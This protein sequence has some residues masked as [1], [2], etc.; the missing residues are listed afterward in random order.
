MN[1]LRNHLS[2]EPYNGNTCSINNVV[3][4]KS[5]FSIHTWPEYDYRALNIITCRTEIK[6][7]K[8]L[9][10]LNKELGVGLIS[11]TEVKRGILDFPVRILYKPEV[12]EKCVI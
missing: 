4:S 7:K 5:H 2:V 6:S 10:F 8:A 9:D 3:I 12:L 1:Y 11:V